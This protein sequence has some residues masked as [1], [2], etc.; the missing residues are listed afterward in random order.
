MTKA[1]S[2]CRGALGTES[3]APAQRPA[4]GGPVGPDTACWSP[5]RS[6]FQFQCQAAVQ[7]GR[8]RAALQMVH[9]AAPVLLPLAL[10]LLSLLAPGAA[11][12]AG[13]AKNAS[14]SRKKNVLLLICD[15]LRTQLKVYGHADYMLTPHIDAFAAGALVFD[16]AFTNYPYC[17]PSRNSFMSGRMPSKTKAWNFIDHFREP[18][19]GL[20][21]A[22]LPQYLKN[23]GYWTVGS[24]KLFH[25]GLPPNE[26]NAYSWSE[27]LVD[28]GGN[29]GCN[30]SSSP[31]GDGGKMSCELPD[32]IADGCA[33]NVNWAATAAHFEAAKTVESPFFIGFGIHRPHL[34]WAV[35][36]RFFRQYAPETLPL[37][38]HKDIPE[39]MAPRSV[40]PF[41]PQLLTLSTGPV[42]L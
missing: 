16:R 38:L 11:N 30:C 19:T 10:L 12:S 39:G 26:D 23:A 34:P 25:P 41:Q 7:P 2:H 24:G 20:D 32:D 8:A 15:D 28:V 3:E 4:V 40:G 21:W 6:P 5:I 22:S 13:V 33:D 42:S 1:E 37:A 17:A 18:S 27:T 35:P 29:E 36:E 31:G 14:K 9:R